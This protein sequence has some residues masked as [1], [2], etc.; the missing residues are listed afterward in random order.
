MS[1]NFYEDADPKLKEIGD[2]IRKLMQKHKVAGCFQ[3]ASSTH[4][5]FGMELPEWSAIQITDEGLRVKSSSER[6][7]KQHLESSLHL[8]FSMRDCATSQA[9]YLI[10][11]SKAV[12]TVLKKEGV[13]IDHKTIFQKIAE[14]EK[15]KSESH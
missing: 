15:I 13:E 12:E 8:L 6:D 5:E 7:G 11:F 2:E 10:K 3:L 4:A 1:S 14:D 9:G